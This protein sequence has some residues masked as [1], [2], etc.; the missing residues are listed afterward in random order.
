MT[1]SARPRQANTSRTARCGQPL[2]PPASFSA[3]D[4]HALTFPTGFLHRYP[5]PSFSSHFHAAK[6]NPE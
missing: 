5:A 2:T 1:Y 4:T 6:M 3:L